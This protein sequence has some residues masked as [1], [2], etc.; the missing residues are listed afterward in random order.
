MAFRAGHTITNAVIKA[1]FGR[2]FSKANFCLQQ[3]VP[4]SARPGDAQIIKDWC[5]F[6]CATSELLSHL[7]CRA[8]LEDFL[9]A[10]ALYIPQASNLL[11]LDWSAAASF[12]LFIIFD[13]P[14]PPAPLFTTQCPLWHHGGQRWLQAKISLLHLQK[15]HSHFYCF[16]FFLQ[17]RC[18]VRK[19]V[20]V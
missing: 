11:E 19:T 15:K 8:F 2:W 6:F 7:Q 12:I 3:M 16:F 17:W 4:K 9:Q 20:T 10:D 18:H 13:E 1:V 14:P 5:T